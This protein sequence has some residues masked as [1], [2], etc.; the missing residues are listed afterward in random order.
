MGGLLGPCSHIEWPAYQKG[1]TVDPSF[2]DKVSTFTIHSFC[3]IN[4]SLLGI[5]KALP[6]KAPKPALAPPM[7]KRQIISMLTS[8][9]HVRAKL[10]A[11]SLPST[12]SGQPQ[13]DFLAKVIKACEALCKVANLPLNDIWFLPWLSL[14]PERPWTF[15]WSMQS[16]LP[17]LPTCQ[18]WR[19]SY[20]YFPSRT[21][22]FKPYQKRW[23]MSW[24][25]S[26]NWR[27]RQLYWNKTSISH[28]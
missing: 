15:W 14:K 27:K 1:V 26:P 12:S 7:P 20:Q 23:M 28:W 16:Y 17:P 10:A 5:S 2:K 21:I 3:C 8:M 22:H 24:P 18:S 6:V 13:N 19:N 11:S 9:A 25:K 4:L